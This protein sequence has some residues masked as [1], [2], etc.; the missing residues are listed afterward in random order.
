ML[1]RSSDDKGS[2]RIDLNSAR[3]GNIS[4]YCFIDGYTLDDP[5]P[6]GFGGATVPGPN[7][8]YDALSSG[9]DQVLVLRD[10]KT[11]GSSIVNEAHISYTRL[12]NLLGVPKGGVGVSLAD[13][14]ISNGTQG[15]Q[16]GFPQYAGV[17]TLY[18]NTFTVGANPFFLNQVNAGRT[19]VVA[20]VPFL[21]AR[22]KL[23]ASYVRQRN[24]LQHLR[25]R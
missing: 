24:V 22:R 13:Q 18:F 19:L 6:V 10:T 21:G 2:A 8:A 3:Y 14:G 15:I 5:Y 12:S 9:K 11:V 7:G 1:F 20:C 4:A 17:E 25:G 23:V 16:Q